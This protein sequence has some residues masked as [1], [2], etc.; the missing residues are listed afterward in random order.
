MALQIPLTEQLASLNTSISDKLEPPAVSRIKRGIHNALRYNNEK[1]TFIPNIELERLL[2]REAISELIVAIANLSPG[3]S[4]NAIADIVDQIDPR[5]PK[6]PNDS[7]KRIFAI[8]IMVGL[9]SAIIHFFE[10]EIWDRHLPFEYQKHRSDGQLEYIKDDGST[11][12]C[13]F[14]CFGSDHARLH[15][16]Q[17]SQWDYMAPSFT[18]TDGKT[19]H[20]QIQYS[21]PLPFTEGTPVPIQGGSSQVTR[22]VI[23]EGHHDLTDGHSFAVKRLL[24]STD[25]D[26][27]KEVEALKLVRKLGH[28]HLIELLATF[29][30]RQFYY[31]IFR[32]AD[33]DLMTFW[34]NNPSPNPVSDT[35]TW[36]LQQCLGIA[37]GLQ[38]IH[39]G[40]CSP[41]GRPKLKGRHGDIKPANILRYAPRAGSQ[42]PKGGV[43]KIGDFGLSRF[44]QN[45]SYRRHYTN[46]FLATRTYRAPEGDLGGEISYLWDLWPL[47]CLYLEFLTW[48]LQGWDA[49]V[50]FSE[51]RRLEDQSR[52]AGVNEDKFFNLNG[53]KSFGACRKDSVTKRINTLHN[54]LECTDLIHDFLDVISQDLIRVRYGRRAKCDR[55]VQRLEA[56][57]QECSKNNAYYSKP[58]QRFTTRPTCESDKICN[59]GTTV[60]NVGH[61]YHLEDTYREATRSSKPP[62]LDSESGGEENSLMQ[63]KNQI[64]PKRSLRTFLDFLGSCFHIDSTY[65][66]DTGRQ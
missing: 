22:V 48:L 14:Q 59:L 15:T 18:F 31:L 60:P 27:K 52:Y 63:I 23:H 39:N 24:N 26:F 49:V 28:P 41:P 29:K 54:H 30:Y 37:K 12:T 66:V 61:K 9:P 13:P 2:T 34:R 7:R 42:D 16:F 44:H 43:L 17:V 3:E 32:W 40:H 64:P 6:N 50:A 1:A 8:L 47:G 19:H 11:G 62:K 46:G 4:D 25:E 45:N 35:S 33:D 56:M 20:Y 38:L 57:V 21:I 36:T 51:E 58:R 53:M 10:A 5:H 65:S 55:I